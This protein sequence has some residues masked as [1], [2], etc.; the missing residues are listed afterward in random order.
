MKEITRIYKKEEIESMNYIFGKAE[1]NKA[2]TKFELEAANKI[3]LFNRQ[4]VSICKIIWDNRDNEK[5]LNRF[6]NYIKGGGNNGLTSINNSE[7]QEVESQ[8]V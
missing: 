5:E 3:D 7:N 2:F 6:L 4:L 8:P 1:D